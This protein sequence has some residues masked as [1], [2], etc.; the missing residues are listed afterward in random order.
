VI[1]EWDDQKAKANAKKHG[2]AFE[3]AATVLRDPLSMTFLDPDHS[4]DEFRYLTIGES[5]SGRIM[6]VAHTDREEVV[7][8]ISARPATRSELRFYEEGKPKEG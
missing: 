6:M 2:V 5:S 8:L 1:V 3:D 4:I 7:R